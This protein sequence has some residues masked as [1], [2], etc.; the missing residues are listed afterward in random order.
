M[1]KLLLEKLHQNM[2]VGIFLILTLSQRR[3]KRLGHRT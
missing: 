3:M 1:A 2:L